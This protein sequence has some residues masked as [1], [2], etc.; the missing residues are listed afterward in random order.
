MLALQP[1]EAGLPI[2]PIE[3]N[4]TFAT[5]GPELFKMVDFPQ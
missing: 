1:N 2:L 4:P 3:P 5:R